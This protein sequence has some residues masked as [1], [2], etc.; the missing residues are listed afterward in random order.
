MTEGQAHLLL[1]KKRSLI[2]CQTCDFSCRFT[3]ERQNGIMSLNLVRLLKII[4]TTQI[5]SGDCCRP[6]VD[7][8]DF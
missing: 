6:C 7:S 2:L 5:S 4:N 8:V 3:D 1:V